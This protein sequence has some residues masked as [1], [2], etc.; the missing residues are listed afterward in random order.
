MFWAEVLAW[1]GA[2]F[3]NIPGY[4]ATIAREEKRLRY[5]Y[6]KNELMKKTGSML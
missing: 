1:V 3:I 2:D 6:L 5:E 4:Y